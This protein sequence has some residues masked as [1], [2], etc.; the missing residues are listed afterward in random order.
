MNK[1]ALAI[2]GALGTFGV[3][4]AFAASL[5]G[6]TSS[7]LGADQTVVTSCDSDGIALAYTNSYDPATNAYKTSAVTMSGVNTNCSGK[8]FKLTLSDG[9]VS[10]GETSGTVTLTSGSQVVTLA[11]PVDTKSVAKASL[12]ITG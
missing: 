12:V 9:T 7:S 1:K 11:S 4:T 10:L 5:G 8:S 3:L 6:L 2:V